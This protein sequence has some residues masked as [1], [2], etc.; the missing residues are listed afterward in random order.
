MSNR[1]AY[2]L[3]FVSKDR[4]GIVA[5]VTK[6]LYE[7]GFNI[8]DSSSTLLS[9]IFSMILLVEHSNKM[10]TQEIE[11]LFS[12]TGLKISAYEI[13]DA[14]SVK[15]ET[16]NRYIISVYGADKPGIIH[17]ITAKLYEINVNIADLQTHIAGD[18]QDEVYIM[19]L[20]VA[21]PPDTEEEWVQELKK[22]ADGI[23]TDITIR[24][25]ETYEL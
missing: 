19:I 25:L 14:R 1:T 3:T 12:A 20:E 9:G 11:L 6:V 23:G 18:A 24:R 13:S 22:T 2:A 8:A 7:N 15:T 10:S 4:T 5:D 17:H 21:L 16:D